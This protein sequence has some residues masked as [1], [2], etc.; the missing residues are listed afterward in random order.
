MDMFMVI[1]I[2]QNKLTDF[3]DD[4][5]PGHVPVKVGGKAIKDDEKTLR[6]NDDGNVLTLTARNFL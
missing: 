2:S 4:F 6:V 1:L 5:R 3:F